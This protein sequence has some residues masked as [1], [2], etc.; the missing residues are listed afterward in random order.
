MYGNNVLKLS[1]LQRI[2]TN[3]TTIIAVLR[4]AFSYLSSYTFSALYPLI[5]D[6]RNMNT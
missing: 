6:Q 5:K 2:I 3:T 1:Y 4:K